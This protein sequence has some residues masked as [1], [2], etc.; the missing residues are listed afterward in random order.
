MQLSAIQSRLVEQLLTS[1]AM[2]FGSFVTKSGRTSPYFFNFGQLSSGEAL[3][4]AADAY[5]E[6]IAK[7]HPRVDVL[8]G[9]AYKGIPLAVMTS[10]ALGQ[11]LRRPVSFCFNRKEV[12]GHGEGGQ[13]VGAELIPGQNIV[14]IEDVLTGGTSLR[15]T[16]ELLSRK[17]LTVSGVV[18]GIDRQERGLSAE[19]TARQEVEKLMGCGIASI[20]TAGEILDGLATSDFLG[21][22]WINSADLNAARAYLKENGVRAV[23][24]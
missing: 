14:V 7:L 20:C 3:M 8:Y 21:K 17:Q 22:R 1:G 9:P 24:L 23:T 5:A 15:E 6:T 12:K 10:Y 16:H 4:K 11:R 19:V 2:R 18:I 13:F